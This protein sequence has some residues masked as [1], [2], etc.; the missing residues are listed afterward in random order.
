VYV[1]PPE[2]IFGCESASKEWLLSLVN[3][4]TCT[5]YCHSI[6]FSVVSGTN[7]CLVRMEF[8]HRWLPDP[9]TNTFPFSL[10]DKVWKFVRDGSYKPP[11]VRIQLLRCTS[12]NKSEF[13]QAISTLQRNL[14]TKATLGT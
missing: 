13:I 8:S 14:S 7:S 1:H 3:S 4:H 11:K 5:F 12:K 10:V 9:T 6:C 2:L